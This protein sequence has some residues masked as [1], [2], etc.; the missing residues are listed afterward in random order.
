MNKKYYTDY[1]DYITLLEEIIS[2][3]DVMLAQQA[4]D[5]RM[6]NISGLSEQE[7]LS[8]VRSTTIKYYTDGEYSFA[9]SCEFLSNIDTFFGYQR[10]IR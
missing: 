7:R 10:P 2:E 3:R 8:R 9:P 5:E 1:T 4:W 6:N